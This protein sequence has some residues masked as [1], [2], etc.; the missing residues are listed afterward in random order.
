LL[1][2]KT[3]LHR[4]DP[5]VKIFRRKVQTP[6]GKQFEIRAEAYRRTEAALAGNSRSPHRPRRPGRVRSHDHWGF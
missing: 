5:G 6:P 2:R 4:I 1:E 3:K